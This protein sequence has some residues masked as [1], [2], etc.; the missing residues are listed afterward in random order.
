M[1]HQRPL[2]QVPIADCHPL[3]LLLL[4]PAL[5][6]YNECCRACQLLAQTCRPHHTSTA[7][8]PHLALAA[9]LVLRGCEVQ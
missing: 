2:R 7:A 4:L 6:L 3:L 1:A 9:V 5:H 8:T